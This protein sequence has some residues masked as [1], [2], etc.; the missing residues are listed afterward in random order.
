MF[1]SGGRRSWDIGRVPSKGQFQGD[2]LHFGKAVI[3]LC[4]L[5][6]TLRSMLYW[7]VIMHLFSLPKVK[8]RKKLLVLVNPV[9]GRGRA[10]QIWKQVGEGED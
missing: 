3:W 5:V 6:E 7:I 4:L 9:G 2:Q 10:V 1:G 8:K